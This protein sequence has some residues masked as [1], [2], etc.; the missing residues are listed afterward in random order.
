M[1]YWGTV[2]QKSNELYNLHTAGDYNLNKII[3]QLIQ[4]NYI[5][6][7]KRYADTY[8]KNYRRITET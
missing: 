6:K 5:Y 4:I 3:L 2:L 8:S 7:K 1:Q